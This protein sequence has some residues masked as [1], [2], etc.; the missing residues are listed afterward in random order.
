MITEGEFKA[1][2]IAEALQ[3]TERKRKFAVIGLQGVS[4]GLHRE[5]HIVPTP[6]EGR[7]YPDEES[8]FMGQRFN[9]YEA[10]Y[11]YRPRR[12]EESVLYF[13]LWHWMASIWKTKRA[14]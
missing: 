13:M 3:N 8:S 5:K 1:L 7:Q 11:E 4:G 9:I 14:N 6:D 2:A 10:A 12:P